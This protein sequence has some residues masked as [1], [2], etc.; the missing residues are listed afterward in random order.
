MP[1]K[2]NEAQVAESCIAAL[3]DVIS[4][5]EKIGRGRGS[6]ERFYVVSDLLY[7]VG[8]AIR[9]IDPV[10]I[11]IRKREEN[12]AQAA[13]TLSGNGHEVKLLEGF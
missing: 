8:E 4:D 2:T 11:E 13:R 6:R 5:L 12:K 1:R 7:Q 10:W 9:S 3:K